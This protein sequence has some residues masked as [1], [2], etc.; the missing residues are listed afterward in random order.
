M[1][2]AVALPHFINGALLTR[3]G[4]TA[5]IYD[6]STGAVTKQV[7]LADAGLVSEAVASAA[8]AFPAWAATPA[9]LRHPW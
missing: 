5:P 4:R 2:E 8:A 3:D 1:S 7:N 6:P 9:H